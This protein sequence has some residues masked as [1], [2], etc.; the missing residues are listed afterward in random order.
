M[1]ALCWHGKKDVRIDNVP[2][3]T[4]INDQD[5]IIRVTATAIC[6]SDLH[7]YNGVMPMME[8]GDILGHEFMGEVVEVGSG[9]KKLK[10]GDKVLVPFTIACGKCQ[11]CKRKLYSLC[12]NSNPN[13]ELARVQMGQAQAAVYG[14]SHLLGG[15][16][17][18]Q[19]EYVR[20]PFSNVGPIKIPNDIPDDKVLF[21]SDV[22]PTGYMAA[23]N[24]D[25]KKGD[26]V[27]IWGCGPVGQFAI[28]S[29]WMFGAGRVIAIDCLPERLQMAEKL[30]KAEI[31]N[32]EDENV[33]DA[34]M[35]MTK[36]VGPDCCIDAVGCEAHVG[37]TFDSYV[38][39][40]K[41]ATYLTSARAHVLREAIECC[42][43]GGTVSIPGVYVGNIDNIPFGAAMNKGLTFKMGQTHV[44]RY[45]E[46]LLDK[47]LDGEIDPS[48]IITHR[49]KLKDAPDG[50]KMFNEKENGCIKIVMTP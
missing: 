21:L 20:V 49:L 44:Q 15:F 7:L 23:E 36:G 38:D 17:G 13:A 39:R 10:V 32:F 25:I 37:P 33:Y 26:T 18:G 45:L 2:D 11:Y 4:I 29:A 31:I 47:I 48:K 19:A 46:P 42:A 8:S 41:Q 30:G 24:A 50:Y 12:D 14:Y 1:K 34:L 22:F 5:A 9:N 28:Q 6:G 35:A 3:P 40:V 43:K 27:A 16:S